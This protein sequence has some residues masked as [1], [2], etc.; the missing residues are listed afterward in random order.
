PLELRAPRRVPASS[1]RGR[2]DTGVFHL[3]ADESA[4]ER[5]GRKR[6]DAARFDYR[7]VPPRGRG[8]DGHGARGS[9]LALAC[10]VDRLARDIARARVPNPLENDRTD[11]SVQA[12]PKR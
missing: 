1:P 9:V 11:L 10:T 12:V 3:D 4:L 5:R 6:T 8:A 2:S 7:S